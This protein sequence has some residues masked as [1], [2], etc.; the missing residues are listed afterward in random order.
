MQEPRGE[1]SISPGQPDGNTDQPKKQPT[2]IIKAL[3]SP[4]FAALLTAV[5]AIAVFGYNRIVEV[6]QRLDELE[7]EARL[8]LDPDGTATA[9]PEALESYY[10]VQE[11]RRR[12][13]RIEGIHSKGH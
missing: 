1:G 9:S 6:D 8:L 13:E 7:K 10:G 12:I 5:S 11:L 4:L 3:E 2:G